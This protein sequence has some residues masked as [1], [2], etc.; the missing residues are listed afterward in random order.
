MVFSTI[1][2]RYTYFWNLQQMDVYSSKFERETTSNK[3]LLPFILDRLLVG[4]D[5]YIVIMLSIAI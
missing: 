4:S 2:Q 1:Q 3:I 5:F